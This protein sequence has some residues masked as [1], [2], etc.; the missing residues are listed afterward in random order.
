MNSIG[1]PSLA[2]LRDR[3]IGLGG[4]L[5][6]R[7]GVR[8][9]LMRHAVT[10]EPEASSVGPLPIAVIQPAFRAGLMA[11]A[12][13]SERTPAGL[14]PARNAA[15]HLPAVAPPAQIEDTAAKSAPDFTIAVVHHPPD[16][17]ASSSLTTG[18][19]GGRLRSKVGV[20][21]CRLGGLGLYNL[22][23]QLF[24]RSQ[25]GKF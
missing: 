6:G 21:K 20:R 7:I 23:P 24:W 25:T 19:R 2:D 1:S 3:L 10:Q 16:A 17:N 4:N 14:S 15:V 22:G 5:E 9:T 12:R 18:E 13:S 8:G 11:G